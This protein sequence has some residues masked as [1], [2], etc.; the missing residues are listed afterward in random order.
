M[1]VPSVVA[2]FVLALAVVGGVYCYH[3]H[4]KRR[5]MEE[6][7]RL[8]RAMLADGIVSTPAERVL[9]IVDRIS[10]LRC[11]L[12]NADRE[13]LRFV[14]SVIATRQ[15]DSAEIHADRPSGVDDDVAAYI[16]YTLIPSQQQQLL[17]QR[18]QL[19]PLSPPTTT[20]QQGATAAAEI[21]SVAPDPSAVPS[22]D[23]WCFDALELQGSMG[24]SFLATLG[25]TAFLANGLFSAF[26]LNEARLT[27]YLR[28]VEAH[29]ST[30]NPYHNAA[31]AGD[32]T[33]CIHWMLTHCAAPF[34][35]STER[36]ALLFAGLVHDVEHGG[37]NN[38]FLVATSSPIAVAYNDRSVLENMHASKAFQYLLLDE[39]SLDF[40]RGLPRSTF[41][42]FRGLAIS[43]ILATDMARHVELLSEFRSRLLSAQGLDPMHSEGDRL[44]VMKAMV[45]VADLVNTTR[46]WP[47]ALKWAQRI[48]EENM[49]QGDDERQRGLAVSPMMDRASANLAKAQASFLEFV[50]LPL[51]EAL[52]LVLPELSAVLV[53]QLRQNHACWRARLS[54]SQ[55][56]TS[57]SSSSQSSG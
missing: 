57:A 50:V 48:L 42:E 52:A 43:L 1:V 10:G 55:P 54:T 49:Q 29:Y 45:K 39:G 31:H 13:D 24:G 46:P 47:I 36:L 51:A 22:L 34:L 14:Y 8:R 40:L 12:S 6:N 28:H 19:L 23:E 9:D 21:V 25:T 18:R 11:G 35:G 53:H 44:L 27:A 16:E 56:A 4:E 37:R 5:L 41:R 33:Q 7:A 30:E 2:V 3:R 15:L 26:P 20:R 38:A 17:Q 32:V